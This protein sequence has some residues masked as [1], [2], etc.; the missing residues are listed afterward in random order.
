MR[1][2]LSQRLVAAPALLLLAACAGPEV[3]GERASTPATQDPSVPDDVTRVLHVDAE[4]RVGSPN[5]VVGTVANAVDSALWFSVATAADGRMVL[6][7][8]PA[9]AGRALRFPAF[10]PAGATPAAALLVR[11]N[12][13][14]DPLRPGE[15]DFRFGARF[16][17]DQES[18]GSDTDDGDNL[19]QRGVFESDTQY[20]LQIDRGVP[21]CLVRGEDGQ[22][23]VKATAEVERETWYAVSCTRDGDGVELRVER[24]DGAEQQQVVRDP[25]RT[26]SVS[27]GRKIPL[28][29]GG[30]V[31]PRGQVTTSSTDQFNGVVDDVFLEYPR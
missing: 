8:G 25:G 21:S 11:P 15:R 12:G 7:D 19:M 20:K 22:V 31:S 28:A 5:D 17:L 14:H 27:P 30:K 18:D 4:G 2:R 26:G 6:A 16:R 10:S 24:D 23:L 13:T 29:I 3:G 1:G 9:G